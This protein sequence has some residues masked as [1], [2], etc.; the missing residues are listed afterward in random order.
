MTDLAASVD[1]L[2]L[3]DDFNEALDA[4]KSGK[5]DSNLFPQSIDKIRSW[6]QSKEHANEMYQ[7]LK[8]NPGRYLKGLKAIGD[9]QGRSLVDVV[10]LG[11]KGE[12][13]FKETALLVLNTIK[14]SAKAQQNSTEDILFYVDS[15][16][17][18]MTGVEVT[19]SGH[20]G[21]FLGFLSPKY[22]T[23]ITSSVLF[24]CV[25]C[26]ET[27]IQTTND[28][29]EGF[30]DFIIEMDP[31]LDHFLNLVVALECLFPI[32]PAVC[33]KVYTSNGCRNVL[34]KYAN[35][36]I[37]SPDITEP[38]QVLTRHLLRLLSSSCITDE[39]R[40]YNSET[41]MT[42]LEV[43]NKLELSKY[44]EIKLLCTLSITKLWSFVATKASS[45]ITI[46]NLYQTC[47]D[48]MM[49]YQSDTILESA[50]ESLAYL[51][52]NSSLRTKFRA[53]VMAIGQL[54]DILRQKTKSQPA[55]S[56]LI[57]GLLLVVSNL[58]KIKDTSGSTQEAKTVNYLKLVA[59]PKSNDDK[60]EDAQ[61]IHNFN[62]ALLMDQGILEVTSQIKVMKTEP[63]STPS[64]LSEQFI[65]I[66]NSIS[67]NQNKPV[68][69]KLVKDGG[70]NVALDYLVGSSKVNKTTGTT[71]PINGTEK[72][73]ETRLMAIRAVA[74]MIIMV[75]PELCFN[76][77]DIMTCL[78]FIIELLGPNIADYTGEI[79]PNTAKE[80][81]YLYDK[82]TTIDK[83]EGLLALT[84]LSSINNRP[85]LQDAIISRGFDNYIDNFLID[86]NVPQLQKAAW[87]L[88]SN[89]MTKP[90]MLA[91]FFNL[92]D[93]QAAKRL[94]VAILMLDLVDLGLQ[95]TIA[96]MMA[97]ATSEFD[98]ILLVLV[99]H[100]KL[101][102]EIVR[103]LNNQSQDTELIL[104]LV[105]VVLDMV[106]AV[107][108]RDE[109]DM[110]MFRKD[111]ELKKALGN[112][113]KTREVAE[114][115]VE[116]VRFVRFEV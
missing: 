55:N 38:I 54:V 14:N 75:N 13:E 31:D 1:N 66:V 92:E 102:P 6:S 91:K 113:L 7:T 12:E 68:R 17:N 10:S 48:Y 97:N 61:E 34:T 110:E 107:A 39:C 11:A 73:V 74:R 45:D 114:V 80:D 103:I 101:L 88:V 40:K 98:M 96:G 105:Y 81:T 69:Q 50:V 53:D 99:D 51:T 84:N 36:V 95:I 64:A 33:T 49:G 106:Y 25:K 78:P 60:K 67:S 22:D 56:S 93:K 58:M 71:R 86:S 16:V 57:Y 76:K 2:A 111:K 5:V 3:D 9:S 79:T 43:A 59:T 32:A 46:D 115:V 8:H 116:I 100:N 52:L 4:L 26:L 109:K 35:R 47:I 18:L 27:D 90:T 82:I 37:E 44:G 63:K 70:I 104:R 28:T 89:L 94:D 72:I 23:N 15:Y 30:F 20:L 62:K 85:Q 77:Y 29:I 87:E 24:I 41:Y 108:N 83:Y 21:V 19:E 42:L 112:G 65:V